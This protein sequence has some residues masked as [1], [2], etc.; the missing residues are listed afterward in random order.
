MSLGAT[1]TTIAVIILL[2]FGFIISSKRDGTFSVRNFAYTA[3]CISLTFVLYHVRIFQMPQGGS[4]TLVSTIFITLV[5]YW[6]GLKA[7]ITAGITFGLL[8]LVVNPWVVHPVQ[9][10]LDYPIASG[11]MGLSGLFRKGKYSLHI[12]FIIGSLFQLISHV[13]SGVLFFYM[14][15]EDAHPVVY[16]ILYNMSHTVPEIIFTLILIS[17]PA[18]KKALDAINPNRKEQIQS[19]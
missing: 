10:L 5:G 17:I 8:V 3:I 4:V 13:L 18:F 12:G 9:M 11:S 6:F 2:F 19:L 1:I 14:Y 7:G 15:A 16:S